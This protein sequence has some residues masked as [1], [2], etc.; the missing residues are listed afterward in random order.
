MKLIFRHL[1]RTATLLTLIVS[2]ITFTPSLSS[3]TT[4]TWVDT[5]LTTGN[6]PAA[7]FDIQCLSE[8]FCRAAGRDAAVFTFDGTRWTSQTLSIPSPADRLAVIT[9]LSCF[10]TT[11]C[12][13]VGSAYDSTSQTYFPVAWI[14]ANGT[15]TA[16]SFGSGGTLRYNGVGLGL[17]SVACVSR[18]SCTAVGQDPATDA[19]I[20]KT[21]ASGT[22]S[23]VTPAIYA[24]YAAFSHIDCHSSVC[25]ASGGWVTEEGTS[26]IVAYST[27]PT[28]WAFTSL[29]TTASADLSLATSVSCTAT[30]F[31]VAV[32]SEA[33]YAH[34]WSISSSA[35]VS[36]WT[37]S[38]LGASLNAD[39]SSLWAIDCV[40]S[41]FCA[42]QGT[43]HPTTNNAELAFAGTFT[44]G[45]WT[46]QKIVDSLVNT[47]DPTYFYAG[48]YYPAPD[49]LS[50]ASASFCVAVGWYNHDADTNL[51]YASIFDGSSWVDAPAASQPAATVQ[52]ARGDSYASAVSCGPHMAGCYVLG[53]YVDANGYEDGVVSYIA[54]ASRLPA[55][56]VNVSGELLVASLVVVGG[57]A[58]LAIS[59]RRATR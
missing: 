24:S 52:G 10:S 37:S 15:W 2:A 21:Y 12:A 58:L 38:T 30:T 13:A 19:A 4:P 48:A 53:R 7:L 18:S 5:A 17:T 25:I 44:A 39:N 33:G 40:S 32:G 6:H 43:Y 28:S 49:S 31:C 3:A 27:S 36:S 1:A 41:Q 50:C 59:R 46:T 11:F 45:S 47:T 14:D 26:A 34:A 57:I 16:Q 29:S 35:Q 23:D 22:W 54:S 9:S 42:A 8:T 56:G 20:I 55:T 51:P